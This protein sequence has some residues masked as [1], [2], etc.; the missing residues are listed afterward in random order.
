[1][2]NWLDIANGWPTCAFV[3][4]LAVALKARNVFLWI[5]LWF[6]CFVDRLKTEAQPFIDGVFADL[7]LTFASVA[8]ISKRFWT[9]NSIQNITQSEAKNCFFRIMFLW[10]YFSQRCLRLHYHWSD[11]HIRLIPSSGSVEGVEAELPTHPLISVASHLSI[12]YVFSL[13]CIPRE[14]SLTT[15]TIIE[16]LSRLNSNCFSAQSFRP[17]SRIILVLQYSVRPDI[18][19]PT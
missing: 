4:S 5:S 17:K 11:S 9:L 1:M 12:R 7:W 15:K 13:C 10:Y 8:L 19:E 6:E 3:L 18:F 14:S 16:S 2:Q